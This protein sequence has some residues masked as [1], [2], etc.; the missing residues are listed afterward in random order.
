M[1]W[2]VVLLGAV[3]LFM[4]ILPFITS[5]LPT[6][7]TVIPKEGTYYSVIITILGA[8]IIYLGVKRL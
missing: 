1:R 4:G 5:Y 8:V 2:I 6:F 7:L 3:I